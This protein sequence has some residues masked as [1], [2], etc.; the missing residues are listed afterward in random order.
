MSAAC[1]NDR[2]SSA[3]LARRTPRGDTIACG[4]GPSVAMACRPRSLSVFEGSRPNAVCPGN[5]VLGSDAGVP[6]PHR[7]AARPALSCATTH[8]AIAASILMSWS[9]SA[10]MAIF[11]GCRGCLSRRVGCLDRIRCARR[12]Y[13]RH[14][15]LRFQGARRARGA[16]SGPPRPRRNKSWRPSCGA[17]GRWSAHARHRHSRAHAV[18]VI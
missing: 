10:K 18:S 1:Q 2:V 8:R 11:R 12:Y 6:R 13:A 9:R 14:R 4:P 15:Q 5:G 17:S 16:P 7:N 3:L